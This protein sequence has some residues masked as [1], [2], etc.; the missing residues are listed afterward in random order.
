MRYLAPRIWLWAHN[1]HCWVP[2]VRFL[3]DDHCCATRI[4]FLACDNPC[5]APRI[6]FLARNIHC[7]APRLQFLAHSLTVIIVFAHNNADSIAQLVLFGTC[8]D[9]S[10]SS[11]DLW[12][13]IGSDSHINPFLQGIGCHN[14]QRLPCN[15]SCVEDHKLREFALTHVILA[16]GAHGRGGLRELLDSPFFL[17]LVM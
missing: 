2:R 7:W 17:F 3:D 11:S 12:P 8:Y 5:W 16:P 14:V 9:N 10:I 13:Q 15:A 4:R 6:R 1:D